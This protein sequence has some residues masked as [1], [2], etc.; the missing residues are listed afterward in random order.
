MIYIALLRGINVG[1]NNKVEMKRLKV[2][3][4]E[5]G[6]ENV[7]TYINSGNVIFES[8]VVEKRKLVAKLEKV[9]E[10][11]FGLEIKVLLV[12]D[13]EL[14]LI[15]QSLPDD[16]RNDTEMKCDVMFL[17]EEVDNPQVMEALPIKAEIDVVKYVKGAVIWKVDRENINKTG[18]MKLVG[19][20]L[21]RQMTIRNCNTV[22][23]LWELMNS[24]K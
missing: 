24:E 22:R 18:I 7:R 23:K 10:D 20:S 3:F 4:E 16:W 15:K 9:I 6:M 14:D 5:A 13:H 11:D 19:T 21:Y 17:W 2:S 8:D 1:G 12:A